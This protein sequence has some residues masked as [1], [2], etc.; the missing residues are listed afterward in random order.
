MITFRECF[1]QFL[2]N[3]QLIKSSTLQNFN[4]EDESYLDNFKVCLRDTGLQENERDSIIILSL[5]YI[6]YEMTMINP[7]WSPYQNNHKNIFFDEAKQRRSQEVSECVYTYL[8]MG[9]AHD[10]PTR[11][12]EIQD[13]IIEC[14]KE[15]NIQNDIMNELTPNIKTSNKLSIIKLPPN[16]IKKVLI[17]TI[18]LIIIFYIGTSIYIG[19]VITDKISILSKNICNILQCQ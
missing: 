19:D 13:L 17:G 9:F 4:N 3:F 16:I 5:C 14:E 1:R 11:Q 8:K 12:D 7:K 15:I 2:Y 18:L 10:D 6:D